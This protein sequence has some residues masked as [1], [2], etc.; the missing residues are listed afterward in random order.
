M[1]SCGLGPVSGGGIKKLGGV[2]C[3]AKVGGEGSGCCPRAGI[4]ARKAVEGRCSRMELAISRRYRQ[5]EGSARAWVVR[6]T[7]LEGGSILKARKK[8]GQY[9][10]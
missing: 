2:I 10:G 8:E 6:K 9:R 5:Y 1:A 7:K 4:I 3:V